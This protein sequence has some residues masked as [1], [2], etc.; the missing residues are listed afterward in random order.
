MGWN[1]LTNESMNG[2]N[3]IEGGKSETLCDNIVSKSSMETGAKVN[4]FPGRCKFWFHKRT[5][6]LGIIGLL[7]R[8]DDDGRRYL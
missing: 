4:I 6:Y 7:A 5:P 2:Y 8:Y 3:T 1:E